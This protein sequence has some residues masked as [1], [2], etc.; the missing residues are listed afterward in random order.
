MSWYDPI[1]Y[2]AASTLGFIAGDVPGAV[3]G[4]NAYGGYKKLTYYF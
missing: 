1:G 4:Y 2:G 3:A